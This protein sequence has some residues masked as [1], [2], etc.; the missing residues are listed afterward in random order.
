M[1][2]TITLDDNLTAQ[3]A[4]RARMNQVSVEQVA[5]SI[6]TAAVQESESDKL[7]EVVKRIQTMPPNDSL[8]RSAKGNLAEALR[9]GPSD[10]G[11]DLEAWQRQWSGVE[12]EL[13]AISRANDLAE[14][15]GA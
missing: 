13:K 4:Q 9:A 6:L 3:L 5:I 10:P 12:A 11:F 7:Q 8:V 2:I 14:G 1:A 15:R